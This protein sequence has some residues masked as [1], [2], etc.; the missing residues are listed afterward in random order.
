MSTW[1]KV[2]NAGDSLAVTK[3][4]RALQM[5][6]LVMQNSSGTL[7]GDST[8]P[9]GQTASA[10]LGMPA[11]SSFTLTAPSS[12]TPLDGITVGCD[13]GTINLVFTF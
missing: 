2:L 3:N 13:T 7:T 10:T 5:T 9:P 6:M 1:T 8:T 11:G 12:A 4:M